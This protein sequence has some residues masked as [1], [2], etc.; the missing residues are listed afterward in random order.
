[1][2]DTRDGLHCP[3]WQPVACRAVFKAVGGRPA[4]CRGNSSYKPSITLFVAL[5]KA[6]NCCLRLL[7]TWKRLSARSFRRELL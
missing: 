3:N 5:S 1:M 7:S 4:A 6:D 2:A